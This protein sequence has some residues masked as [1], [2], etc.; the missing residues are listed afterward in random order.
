MP[1][2]N[3]Y[4]RNSK[5]K[6]KTV[7]LCKFSIFHQ[8][9]STIYKFREK[10]SVHSSQWD[11][12]EKRPKSINHNIDLKRIKE[13][14]NRSELIIE[15]YICQRLS[16]NQL[17]TVEEVKNHLQDSLSPKSSPKTI[18]DFIDIVN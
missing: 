1:N 14:L 9:T 8:D 13:K 17:T 11:F 6:N 5:P 3:F 7:I 10:E 18:L 16:E 15:N 4:L 12:K 2:I